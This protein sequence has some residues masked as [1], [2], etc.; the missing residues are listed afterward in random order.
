MHMNFNNIFLLNLRF[1][2]KK[3]KI[4][5]NYKKKTKKTMVCLGKITLIIVN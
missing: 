3:Q 1:S 2:L 5:E 4:I